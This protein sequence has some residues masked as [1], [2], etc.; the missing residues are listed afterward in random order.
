MNE[1][2]GRKLAAVPKFGEPRLQWEQARPNVLTN[3][4]GVLNA[5]GQTIKGLQVD[6]DVF[7]SPRLGQVKYVF[8]LKSYNLGLVERAYQLEVNPRQGLKPTD[9]AYS[10]EHFGEKRFNAD[11]S[12]ATC[13]YSDAWQKFFKTIN[14]TLTEELPDYQGF[15]LK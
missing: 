6:L 10:H 8:S 15:V 14:L 1:I 9:H 12:W 7:I 3:A 13:S 2:E 5:E 11:P 4:F